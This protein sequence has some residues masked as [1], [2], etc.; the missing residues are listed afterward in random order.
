[1]SP[2][3]EQQKIPQTAFDKKLALN[4]AIEDI[5]KNWSFYRKEYEAIYYEKK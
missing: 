1:M 3:G 2:T 4:E 5:K